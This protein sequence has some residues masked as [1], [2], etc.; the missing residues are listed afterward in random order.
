MKKT[1]KFFSAILVLALFVSCLPI[2]SN[3]QPLSEESIN[4]ETLTDQIDFNSMLVELG[5]QA[6]CVEELI[7]NT[8]TY[9]RTTDILVFRNLSDFEEGIEVFEGDV[10]NGMVVKIFYDAES[11][12]EYLIMPSE[13][14]LNP[15]NIIKPIQTDTEL[16]ASIQNNDELGIITQINDDDMVMQTATQFALPVDNIVLSAQMEG[17]ISQYYSS[18]HGGIDIAYGGTHYPSTIYNAPIRAVMTGT[19]VTVANDSSGYGYYV[20]VSHDDGSRTLYAHMTNL[21]SA[22]LNAYVSQ[23]QVIGHV[24]SSGNSTGNHLHF[25]VWAGSSSSTRVDPLTYL[26]GAP[27]WGGP[28]TVAPRTLAAGVPVTYAREMYMRPGDTI[29]FQMAKNPTNSTVSFGL[30]EP[31]GGFNS[32]TRNTDT[33]TAR[34]EGIHKFRVRNEST[35]SV[36]FGGSWICKTN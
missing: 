11:W 22:S 23:G 6:E 34:K 32:S 19:A 4:S 13:S 14:E 5:H 17:N 30:A 12:I 2:T 1:F 36:E 28:W 35:G 10:Q 29:T 24:G 9:S 15:G 27:T 26:T 33:I 3:A 31:D 8:L 18:S 25:E 20:V 21:N 16:E 7:Q